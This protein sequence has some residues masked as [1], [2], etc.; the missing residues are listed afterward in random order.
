MLDKTIIE[1]KF[2]KEF[3]NNVFI[4]ETNSITGEKKKHNPIIEDR[5]ETIYIHGKFDKRG[6]E[7]SIYNII[8]EV[9]EDV[10]G[11]EKFLI[12][13]KEDEDWCDIYCEG[14]NDKRQE[15]L[16]YREKFKYLT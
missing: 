4:S 6:I 15:I 14:F 5:E 8:S 9:L 3:E 2:W 13:D 1:E 12:G 10:A 16:G 11:E 7:Q